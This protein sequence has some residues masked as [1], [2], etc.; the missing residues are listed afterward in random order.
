MQNTVQNS[1][2]KPLTDEMISKLLLDGDI[3]GLSE[4]ERVQYYRAVCE[5]IGLDP[6]TQPFSILKLKKKKPGG[7]YE[8]RTILYLNASGAQQLNRMHNVSHE[9]RD[10]RLSKNIYRVFFRAS[11]PDGRYT[12]SVGVV[13]VSGLEGDDLSNA[14]MRA[15][16]KSK[17]RSTV[18]L[19][20][21]AAFDGAG[22]TVPVTGTGQPP[23]SDGND[24]P[25]PGEHDTETDTDEP[26]NHVF[27]FGWNKGQ[28]IKTIFEKRGRK[29]IKGAISWC[30]QNN[31]FPDF[32]NAAKSFLDTVE[33]EKEKSEPV[34]SVSQGSGEEKEDD[35]PF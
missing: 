30:E 29:E 35:L 26:G 6:S 10:E 13:S 14:I 9:M 27:Q 20:G 15:E 34:E 23:P 18:D 33:S 32:I 19:L 3:T 5:R 28:N 2:G 8:P 4:Y 16:T 7:G 22:A 21:L 31:K 17:R 12:D 11:L 1:R 24:E 25:E